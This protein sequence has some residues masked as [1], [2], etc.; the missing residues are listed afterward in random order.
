M[1][2]KRKWHRLFSTKLYIV[3]NPKGMDDPSCESTIVTDISG[4]TVTA[5]PGKI[6]HVF[7]LHTAENKKLELQAENDDEMVQWIQAIRRCAGSG[8]APG[9]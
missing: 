6:P 4:S 8:G 1:R 7:V 5:K 3:E 9:R 2:P